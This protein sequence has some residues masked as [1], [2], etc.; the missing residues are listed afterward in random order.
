[1]CILI[2]R[3]KIKETMQLIEAVL[4]TLIEYGNGVTPEAIH[5]AA[6]IMFSVRDT[7][8]ISQHAFWPGGSMLEKG[9]MANVHPEAVDNLKTSG[10]QMASWRDI[11]S[12]P[13]AAV[14]EDDLCKEYLT[15]MKDGTIKI[16]P[17]CSFAYFPVITHWMPLPEPPTVN[18][19]G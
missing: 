19:G 13:P 6:N 1:M 14:N 18:T 11:K 9:T 8:E 12:E 2:S 15:Y 4:D 7:L 5:N 17:L 16:L 3:E 10:V